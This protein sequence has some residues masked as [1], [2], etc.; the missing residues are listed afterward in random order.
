MQGVGDFPLFNPT[1]IVTTHPSLITPSKS[2]PSLRGD[3]L[4]CW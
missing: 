2:P 4:L 3:F 1:L